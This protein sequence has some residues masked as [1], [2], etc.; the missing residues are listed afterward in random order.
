[1]NIPLQV[2]GLFPTP[3][4]VTEYDCGETIRNILKTEANNF[5]GGNVKIHGSYSK[6]FRIL[7]LEEMVEFNLHVTNLATMIMKDIMAYEVNNTKCIQ[8]WVSTKQNGEEHQRHSH[9]NS[10][11]SAVYFYEE[12]DKDASEL[13][14]H[15][16]HSVSNTNWLSYSTNVEIQSKSEFAWQFFSIPPEKNRLVLFPSYLEHSVEK[17]TTNSKRTSFAMN[18]IPDPWS[19]D[20][21][22]TTGELNE[23]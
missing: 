7:E 18:F 12:Q 4:I 5:G 10:I 17:N 9:P 19:W 14:F 21:N 2:Y 13:L 20:I 11:V 16:P 22:H 1:M 8:S 3:L 6:N 15:K 23:K